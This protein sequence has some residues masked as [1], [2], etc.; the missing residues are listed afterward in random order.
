MW[1]FTRVF[2]V[3][4]CVFATLGYD[5]F[6]V[7]S[8]S[9]NL[10]L[11]RAIAVLLVLGQHL[12][13]RASV[14]HVLWIPTTSLGLF[15][16]LLFFV[17]TCLVLMY[18]MERSGLSGLSLMKNFHIRRIFRIYPLS[19]LTVLAALALSLASNVNGVAGLSRVAS[20]PGK[21]EVIANLL[22]VQ[23][24]ASTQSVVNVLWSLPFELQMYLLLPLLFLWVR[25]R[26]RF[27]LL[28]ALWAI[29]CALGTLQPRVASMHYFSLCQYLPNFLPGVIAYVLPHRPRLRALFWPL[30]LI[31]LV[32]AYTMRPAVGT[33]WLLCLILGLSLP[34]FAEIQNHGLRWISHHIATYSYGIYLSH[35]FCIW[36]ALGVL[37][38]YSAWIRVPVLVSM[39]IGLPILLYH[40][41]EKPMIGLGIRLASV[42]AS[43]EKLPLN[44]T[45]IVAEPAPQGY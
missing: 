9:A 36:V 27:A 40:A 19:I 25:N 28:L 37:G 39:L 23:N 29:G 7:R 26:R 20:F 41:V 14:E 45:T 34:F 42:Q 11:L 22:L 38:T 44:Q 31:A 1:P 12:L 15:G 13:R 3:A 24:L 2:A 35:Q 21:R 18:S 17:H 30:F 10:D 43:T 6:V 33:G 8:P 4:L 5:G 32:G 16:V